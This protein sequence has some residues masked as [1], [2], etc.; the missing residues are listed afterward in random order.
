[1]TI[2]LRIWPSGYVHRWGEK[3]LRGPAEVRTASCGRVYP[4][5]HLTP[6]YPAKGRHCSICFPEGAP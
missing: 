3:W 4:A 1:M 5:K 6:S 2:A